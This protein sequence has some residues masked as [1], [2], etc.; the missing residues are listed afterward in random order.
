[1]TIGPSPGRPA[2]RPPAPP[3]LADVAND[4]TD[5]AAVPFVARDFPTVALRDAGLPG[6]TVIAASTESRLMTPARRVLGLRLG[7]ALAQEPHA[8]PRPT[9]RAP[10]RH[11]DPDLRHSSR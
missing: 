11:A 4:L 8:G 7:V 10:L 2:S 5:A 1:M 6:A 3:L 9:Q